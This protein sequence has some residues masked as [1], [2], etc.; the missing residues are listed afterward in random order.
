[1]VQ[2][3]VLASAEACFEV[4][5][6]FAQYPQWARGVTAVE[7]EPPEPGEYPAQ[8]HF[9]AEAVGRATRYTLAYDY[10][11]AP[12]VLRW[13]LVDGDLTQ[14]LDGSYTF[15]ADP[16]KP[17]HTKVTYE[18]EIDLR[19]PLPGFAKRRAETKIMEWA[20]EEFR[21]QVESPPSAR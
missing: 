10:S 19:V 15:E 13:H 4:V 20:L 8:V 7:F 9:R 16:D 2:I 3:S 21:R 12:R 6:D 11:E 17:G 5:T 18:L 1:M 14:R